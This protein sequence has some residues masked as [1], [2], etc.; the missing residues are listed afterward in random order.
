MHA[1]LRALD[2]LRLKQG[3]EI[4]GVATVINHPALPS[5][6]YILAVA[7]N[8]ASEPGRSGVGSGANHSPALLAPPWPALTRT[9]SL[10][11][12]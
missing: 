10:L 2:L 11:Q 5:P 7:S 3:D 9:P 4:R 8:A 1:P 6:V 12:A